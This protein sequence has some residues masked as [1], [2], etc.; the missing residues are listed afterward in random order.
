MRLK[1][2]HLAAAL[3]LAWAAP[4][5]AGPAAPALDPAAAQAVPLDSQTTIGGVEVACTGIGETRNDP[6]W[7]AWPIRVEFSNAQRLYETDAA[8]ALIDAKGRTVLTA[9]CTGPWLLLRPTPGAYSVS[10]VL[11]NS[12]TKPRST[13]FQTPARGQL[14]VV[15][16]FPNA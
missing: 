9:S 1:P 11:L 14:R 10:A 4:V 15:I 6:K 12:P 7:A 13:R 3:T 8:V 16:E 2:I 5:A